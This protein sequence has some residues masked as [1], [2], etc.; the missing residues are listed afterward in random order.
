M[1]KHVNNLLLL[2]RKILLRNK[3]EYCRTFASLAFGHSAFGFPVY[4]AQP[5]ASSVLR[6]AD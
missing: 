4:I 1:L 5:P 6:N 2:A 3:R